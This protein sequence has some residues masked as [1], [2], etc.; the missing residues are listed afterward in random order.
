MKSAIARYLPDLLRQWKLDNH[1]A[2]HS[3][4]RHARILLFADASGFTVLTRNLS[5]QGRV[6]F[7]HLTDLLN[8][9]FNSMAEDIAR[10]DGDILK[11]SGD[12]VWCCFPE[13]TDIL[14]VYAEMLS[15]IEAINREHPTC[16]QFPLSLHAGATRGT[17]DLFTIAAANGRAEFEISGAS[18]LAAYRACDLAKAGELCVTS[19]LAASLTSRE[20]LR[21]EQDFVVIRPQPIAAVQCNRCPVSDAEPGLADESLVKYVPEALL[22]RILATSQESTLASEHRQVYIAFVNIQPLSENTDP[23]SLK[24]HLAEIMNAIHDSMARSHELTPSAPATKSWHYSAPSSPP[25]MTHSAPSRPRSKL[26][27]LN[28]LLFATRIGLAAGPLLCGEVGSQHRCEFTVMGNAVNLAARLM[29]KSEPSGLLLD[30]QFYKAVAD[31]CKTHPL[32]LSLKG[33]DLPVPVYAFES[34]R[35]HQSRLRRPRQ[36]FGRFSELEQ[37]R[38]ALAQSASTG[39][40]WQVISGPAGMGK[41]SLAAIVAESIDSDRIIYLDASDSHLRHGG[42]LIFEL[43][44]QSLGI[45]SVGEFLES[46]ADHLGPQWLPL[47]ESIAG[48]TISSDGGLMDLTPELRASKTAELVASFLDQ[49]LDGKVLILDNLESLDSLSASILRSL[50]SR[51]SS[52]HCLVL[53]LDDEDR[54]RVSEPNVTALP[55]EGLPESEIR[56]WL[57]SVFVRGKRESDLENHSSHISRKSTDR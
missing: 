53:L 44:L 16:R 17:L 34:L 36:F 20:V 37:L 52:C 35:A 14:Q 25:A 21:R 56:L 27:Q 1:A 32:M 51:L 39:P 7:E 55:I 8:S 15:T 30:E 4:T 29:T 38:A 33:F 5:S 9:L 24:N 54:W 18:V 47:M 43:L 12:A 11:F 2:E 19:D 46:A 40:I 42:W 48:K 3:L 41:T 28:P 31:S 45:R 50:I 22:K 57:G 26:P 23:A 10:H 13:N 6:G 49:S